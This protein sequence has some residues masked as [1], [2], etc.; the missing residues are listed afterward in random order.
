MRR[1]RLLALL[2]FLVLPA[3]SV[4]ANVLTPADWK[5]LG[6]AELQAATV[7]VEMSSVLMKKGIPTSTFECVFGLNTPLNKFVAALRPVALLTELAAQMTNSADER[8][9]LRTLS[10]ETQEFLKFKEARNGTEAPKVLPMCANEALMIVEADKLLRIY[11]KADAAVRSIMKKINAANEN[12]ASRAD[13]ADSASANDSDSAG[14]FIKRCHDWS[15]EGFR[16][17]DMGYC[18]GAVRTVMALGPNLSDE[19]RFCPDAPPI[20]GI[21]V[22]SR[23]LRA[24]S[25][26]QNEKWLAVMVEAFH[27]KW[28]CK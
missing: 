11:D 5:A 8:A 2:A 24:N 14:N 27:H 7:G 23:H 6:D 20:G 1:L 9:V 25:D 21:G 16:K 22:M 15:A 13:D 28:P 4:S 26:R 12:T 17:Y 19:F 3:W 10:H 18:L